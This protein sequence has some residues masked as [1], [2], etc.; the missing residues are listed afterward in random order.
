[1]KKYLFA[2]IACLAVVS[3]LQAQTETLFG[4]A[5]VRG[6][7]AAPIVEWG[8][9][10]DIATAA[11]GGAA[12]VIGNAFLG[13]YG[14]GSTDFRHFYNT[15]NI[16]SLR[17]AHGGFWV[18]GAVPSHKL[19]HL[20]GSARIGWGAL[21][22]ETDDSPRY[23][24]LD[25]VFVLT[26]E[27]GLELNMATWLRVNCTVG[28]RYLSGVNSGQVF[29]SSDLRGTVMAVGVR[30]GGFGNGPRREDRW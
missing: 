14:M 19:I 25:K 27:I 16:E 4:N 6:A 11:G 12:L 7:F 22:I 24:E 21:D 15:G 23:D 3:A 9:K 26:P 10:D 5:R 8:L 29:D 17:L 2:F 18:G 20:Y 28:Y 30:I 13:A 1:M